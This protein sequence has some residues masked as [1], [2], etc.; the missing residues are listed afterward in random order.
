MK[1][2]ETKKL[3]EKKVIIHKNP[4]KIG[5]ISNVSTRNKKNG[6]KRVILNLKNFNN[7]FVLC[8]HYIWNPSIMLPTSFNLMYI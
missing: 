5:F 2:L 4:E 1:L 8:K 6:N 7:R 3:L